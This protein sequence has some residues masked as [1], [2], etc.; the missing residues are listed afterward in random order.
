M[1]R[2]PPRST[3]FPYTTLFRSISTESDS[4][5]RMLESNPE[6]PKADQSNT[7]LERAYRPSSPRCVST[8]YL[9]W[10]PRDRSEDHT[11]E[12]QSPH[13]LVCPLLLEKKNNVTP[14]QQ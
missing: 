7:A 5:R 6:A 1:I 4:D 8:I 12:L 10:G 3:L 13:H 11:S 2:R 9:L 14:R